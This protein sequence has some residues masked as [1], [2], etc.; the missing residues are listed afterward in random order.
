MTDR[1]SGHIKNGVRAGGAFRCLVRSCSCVHPEHGHDCVRRL[2][3]EVN[4]YRTRPLSKGA[5]VGRGGRSSPSKALWR[6]TLGLLLVSAGVIG[7]SSPSMA[8]A[9]PATDFSTSASL[10]TAAASSA[11]A[12]TVPTPDNTLKPAS[13]VHPLSI[14]GGY[15]YV[16]VFS[17]GRTL[18]VL[19]GQKT[20]TQ[21]RGANAI[22]VY[23]DSGQF[24]RTVTLTTSGKKA[25]THWDQSKGCSLA[26]VGTVAFV[27]TTPVDPV[28][29]ITGPLTAA[30]TADSC[31]SY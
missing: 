20:V 9:T 19:A 26:L 28:L 18:A 1:L 13:D 6:S 22:Q 14:A 24:V 27:V 8:V 10:S 30:I 17:D 4:M 16:C 3:R 12:G 2:S 23:Y 25:A 21:C 15:Y 31:T 29:F 11:P 7:V 5:S